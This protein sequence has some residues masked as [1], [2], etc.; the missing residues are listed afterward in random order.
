M[1]KFLPE[2]WIQTK[3]TIGFFIIVLIAV[4]IFTISY[5]SVV[6]IIKVQNEHVGSDEEFTNLNQLLFE[7]IETESVG[8]MYGVT[9]EQKY[10][11]DYYFHHDSVV[12]IISYL[13]HI[14]NDSSSVKRVN[15]VM[16]LY[17][18]KK[19][20][21]DDLININLIRLR[22]S[23]TE[24]IISTIPDSL[25]Q[26]ITK[27]TYTSI[28]IDS[29]QVLVDT[30]FSSDEGEDKKKGLFRKIGNLFTNKKKSEEVPIAY[31]PI[32]SQQ[33]DSTI[34]KKVASDVNVKQLK[35]ELKKVSQQE[36]KI[37]RLLRNQ[38]NELIKLDRQLTEQIKDIVSNLQAI[39]VMKN[40][41]RRSEMENLRRDMIDRILILVG[42]AVFLMLFFIIWISTDISK[43]KLLKNNI[44]KSKE[45]V[46]KLLKVKE[47]FVAHM[48]HEIRTPLTAIIG[49][50]DNLALN[51]NHDSQVTLTDRI[52]LSAEHLMSLINNVLDFSVLESGNVEF[53]KDEINVNEFMSNI[54]HL[55]ELKAKQKGISLTFEID[56]NITVFESDNLR[57]KQVLIN[58]IGNAIKFTEEGNINYKA[59]L[60]NNRIYFSVSDTGIGIPKD[61][62][63]AVFQMFN[64]VNV[65]LSRKYS[66]TGLGLSISQQIVEAMGGKFKLFSKEGEGSIFSFYI[67]YVK[68]EH[69]E[70][71]EIS[72]EKCYFLD[73]KVLAID[74]D[75]MIC[76]LIDGILRD[77]FLRL[78]VH[79][80]PNVGIK[81]LEQVSYDLFMFDLHMPDVDGLQLLNIIREKKKLKTPLLFLTA[82]RVNSELKEAAK[83]DNVYVMSKPFTRNQ[84]LTKIAEIFGQNKITIEPEIDMDNKTENSEILFQLDGVKSFTGD[85]KEFLNSVIQ[86]FIDNSQEGMDF[87][88]EKMKME[89]N[90][91]D[92]GEKAHKM[93]T[94][95]RQFSVVEGIPLLASLE[96]NKDQ[97][98]T[99]EEIQNKIETLNDL[100]IKLKVQLEDAK[101][102]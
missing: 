68:G 23:G 40:S 47:Q 25:Y 39:S 87:L 58:L 49:F 28:K 56:E 74:D 100:W 15:K 96:K 92:I 71:Y 67:P 46:D 35:N 17:G 76:Q 26:E 70:L 54:Y 34:T 45:K 75:E 79:S 95:F 94:G 10:K 33:V 43:S 88:I 27:Y 3:V 64:Q 5:F 55:F 83:N 38:E 90:R 7:I 30:L 66:G 16:Q 1:S 78:D 32:L 48:S 98:M 99:S 51:T 77:R 21:M 59:E 37:N 93:L 11:D 80:S 97:N 20:L 13:P 36:A 22:Y 62:Q 85:D 4:V 18:K 52:K 72:A 81:S 89:E 91:Q 12:K 8:R 44:I 31:E 65:S 69:K 41:L 101:I 57:L 6:S 9:G 29:T 53:F 50:A 60:K 84:V 102:K 73:K 19:E 24:N 82:D 42:S 2:K 61:K 14:F 63:K 86:T